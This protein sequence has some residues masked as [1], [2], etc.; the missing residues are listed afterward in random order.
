GAEPHDYEPSP[1]DIA[2]IS[3]SKVLIQNGRGLEAWGNNIKQN[4]N[5]SKTAI[6]T[7]SDGIS[8]QDFSEDGKTIVDPHI[9]MDP[10]LAKQIA[11]SIERAFK[12]TDP[13]NAT[14]YGEN[15]AALEVKLDA[16]DRDFREGLANCEKKDIITSHSAFGYLATRYGLTQV[17]I[18]GLSPDME[19]SPKQLS[20]IAA[21]AKSHDIKY[22]F[23]E[24]LASPKLSQ[25]IATEIGAQTL[26]LNPIEGLTKAEL[27]QG[28]N[29]ITIMRENLANLQTALSCKK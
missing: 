9:W 29:Y 10:I 27:S 16:L 1:G 14:V 4:L 17:P 25:T 20:D 2:N 22:I 8:L 24:S 21:F 11:S 18:A 28:K 15:L 5:P 23:F 6:I 12:K 26:V 3:D 7:I 13:N 19:P